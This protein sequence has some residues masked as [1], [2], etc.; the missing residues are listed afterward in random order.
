MIRTL[1]HLCCEIGVKEEQLQPILLNIESYYYEKCNPKYKKNGE[2]KMNKDGTP[3]DRII[4]PCTKELPIIQRKI[5]RFLAMNISP[6]DYAYGGVKK[7]DNVKNANYHKGSKYFFQSDLQD[8]FPFVTNRMV[9]STLIHHGF[10]CDVASIVTKLT[11]YKG[12]LPQGAST[13]SIL[14]NLV[15][16]HRIG[17]KIYDYTNEN[18]LRFT[19]FVDDVTISA[20]ID[21]KDKIQVILQMIYDGGFKISHAKTNY[22]LYS[23]NITGVKMAQNNIKVTDKF[24]QKLDNADGKSEAQVKGEKLYEKRICDVNS[25]HRKV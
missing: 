23:S 3:R 9:Y 11:T 8:F 13:S 22:G 1:R 17:D 4:N 15:F 19:M 21:F 16:A 18:D 24:Q 2:R 7:R 14:A 6:A 10:S 20:S 12:H 5:N 25:K